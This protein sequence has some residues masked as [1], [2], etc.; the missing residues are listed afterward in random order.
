MQIL[1]MIEGNL[2]LGHVTPVIRAVFA[3]F[4]VQDDGTMNPKTTHPMWLDLIPFLRTLMDTMGVDYPAEAT[5]AAM[6][7]AIARRMGKPDAVS[8]DDQEGDGDDRDGENYL[9]S[10]A[11]DLA[12]ALD[13]GHGLIEATAFLLDH[14]CGYGEGLDATT[15]LV[16]RHVDLFDRTIHGYEHAAAVHDALR[17]K[18]YGA[19]AAL[20]EGQ[21]D[22]LLMEI[23]DPNV[24]KKVAARIT[25]PQR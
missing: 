15:C 18:D 8:D 25:V 10:E 20:I 19:A 13:D 14:G 11:F 5:S 9:L 1:K 6:L 2:S 24:R 23:R 16:T 21:I 3:P 7:N 12:V 17:R 22:D 4:G